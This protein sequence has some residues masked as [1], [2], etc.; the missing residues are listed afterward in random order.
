MPDNG[1]FDRL[2][3]Q[4]REVAQPRRIDPVQ[5]QRQHPRLVLAKVA[6]YQHRQET[7]ASL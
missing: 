7:I 1:T 2:N 5:V 3:A 6:L 4:R